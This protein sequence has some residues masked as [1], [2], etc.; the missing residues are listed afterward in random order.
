[1][2]MV[3]PSQKYTEESDRHKQVHE[4][5]AL[6]HGADNIAPATPILVEQYQLG[7]LVH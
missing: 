3:M 5:I 6:F 4:E 2:T 7:S 1:M